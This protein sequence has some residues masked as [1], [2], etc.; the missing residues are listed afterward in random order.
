MSRSALV[1]GDINLNL[2]DGS[3]IW[4][5]SAVQALARAGCEVTLVLKAPVRTARLLDPLEAE[6]GVTVRRPYEEQLLDGIAGNGLTPEQASLTLTALD[7]ERRH[8]IVVLRGRRIVSQVV[9]DG[10]FNGRLWTYLTDI[11][12]S[13]PAMTAEN[14]T[15]LTGV[16][17][18]SQY[19]LCQTEE[20]RCFLEGSVP[21][22]C[23]KCV[24][25]PPVVPPAP[26]LPGPAAAPGVTG[27][28]RLVYTGKFAPRWN[29]Y[30]MTQLPGRLAGRGVRAEL[31]MVGD[32]V[33]NDPADPGY[34][35]R[36]R[37]ALG[38]APAPGVSPAAVP[39]SGL[40]WHGGHSREDAMRIAAS[41]DIGLS[42]RHP[43]LDASLELSTKVLEFGMLGL[44]VILNR[45]PMHEA[46]LGADYPMFAADL[47][48]VVA[49]AENAATDP[50]VMKLAAS[51][52]SA[53]AAEYTLD[54]TVSRVRG[55]LDAALPRAAAAPGGTALRVVV[56]G[57]DLKFFSPLLDYLRRQPG[58]EVR[59]DH[60]RTLSEH[61]EQVSEEMARWADVVICEWCGPNAIWYSENK[62]RGSRLV[63]RLHRFEL[64]ARYPYLVNVKAVDQVI[65]VNKHYAELVTEQTGWASRKIVTLPNTVDVDQ[66]DRP[67]LDGARFSLGIVGVVPSRKRLDL[68]LDVLEELRRDDERYM[69]YVKSGMPWDLWWIWRKAEERGHYVAALHRIQR[70]PL[71]RGAVVFDEA[72]R[73]V[74]AWLRRV[75]F[76]LSTSDDESFHVAPAEGMASRAVPVVRH[77]PGAETVYDARWI[78]ETP[79]EM[80]AAIA[81]IGSEEDWRE[82]G[83]LA[84]AQA[85]GSFEMNK[86][87]ATWQ[88][89]L[90]EDLPP[91]ASVERYP[92]L[93]GSLLGVS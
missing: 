74:P 87:F 51:R 38:E 22:A 93:D 42:W 92:V 49:I 10:A 75:G 11:P 59:V 34:H 13:I 39:P 25:L 35:R 16:A 88:R 12:Q 36:M 78:H 24:L 47:Q 70:S 46:L 4:V 65:C 48:D 43:E 77:W 57:H 6:P 30:E 85:A 9:A 55:Y 56:A 2:I 68:A 63:V 84:R 83:A 3:A 79:T 72:G 29:T 18:A 89:L 67:K 28:L 5:Q 81:G 60:W 37:A 33:H 23:G 32:K 17:D 54:K 7:A 52:T 90:R 15:W 80:A 91:A 14:V 20:L 44:P 61:D 66:L 82:A 58:L 21:A 76:V 1:Y 27:A 31:H 26:D 71:L 86:V 40:V 41:C 53:A 19:L 64:Y 62:R 45:T 8:D 50:E 73:D 69:L